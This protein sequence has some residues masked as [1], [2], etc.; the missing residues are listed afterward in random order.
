MASRFGFNYMHLDSIGCKYPR[1]SRLVSIR[2]CT[3]RDA[4]AGLMH[5]MPIIE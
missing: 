2:V 3:S 1:L 5:D 4:D